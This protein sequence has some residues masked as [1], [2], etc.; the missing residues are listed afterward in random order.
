[1]KRLS[2][3]LLVIFVCLLSIQVYASDDV[4]LGTSDT[5]EDYD[6][7]L[8]TNIS[9]NNLY[10]AFHYNRVNSVPQKNANI[11][12]V[13]KVFS[14]A[15]KK[16]SIQLSSDNGLFVVT[17]NTSASDVKSIV[18]G[19]AKGNY[20]ICC[21]Q[22]KKNTE[23]KFEITVK[24]ILTTNSSSVAALEGGVTAAGYT[25]KNNQ[26]S[27]KQFDSLSYKVL[28]SWKQSNR[29]SFNKQNGRRYDLG[30]NETLDIYIYDYETLKTMIHNDRPGKIIN[31]DEIAK[32]LTEKL[33]DRS[34]YYEYNFL[35]FKKTIKTVNHTFT[36]FPGSSQETGSLGSQYHSECFYLK[37]GE[38]YVAV[39]YQYGSSG[40]HIAEVVMALGSMEMI[41]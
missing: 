41:K 35:N 39:I 9:V 6:N 15:N 11:A 27:N 21:G 14:I 33:V 12:L 7:T 20:V 13:G 1:M 38:K 32:Y 24:N 31:N 2:V 22:V 25:Y 34:M 29:T 36:Y 10:D 37:Y 17:C 28:T 3:L 40:I 23:S 5:I 19:L 4:E 18:E 26:I 30:N 8:Y 16:T